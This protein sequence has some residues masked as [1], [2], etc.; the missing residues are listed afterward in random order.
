MLFC[1]CCCCWCCFFSA[2][3]RERRAPAFYAPLLSSSS[4]VIYSFRSSCLLFFVVALG[5]FRLDGF[6]F[7]RKDDDRWQVQPTGVSRRRETR[8]GPNEIESKNGFTG[9]FF[10]ACTWFDQALLDLTWFLSGPSSWHL[11]SH[12]CLP[13]AEDCFWFSVS[14]KEPFIGQTIVQMEKCRWNQTTGSGHRWQRWTCFFS[15]NLL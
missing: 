2:S 13:C 4:F 14:G 3:T 15:P 9:C 7:Y 12:C 11:L 5:P 1:C 10:C 6:A 8:N